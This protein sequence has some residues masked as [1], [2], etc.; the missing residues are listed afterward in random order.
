MVVID[1]SRYQAPTPVQ[2]KVAFR[3]QPP[4]SEKVKKYSHDHLNDTVSI[5]STEEKRF[6][7]RTH[8]ETTR[9]RREPED[10]YGLAHWPCVFTPKR[11]ANV[12]SQL[13]LKT[14]AIG[15]FI[16]LHVLVASESTTE[17]ATSGEGSATTQTSSGKR[18]RKWRYGRYKGPSS[19]CMT[20]LSKYLV[21]NIQTNLFYPLSQRALEKMSLGYRATQS[22]R[23]YSC[24]YSRTKR[25]HNS[26]D[27]LFYLHQ[28]KKE[29]RGKHI[30]ML[31][32]SFST[33]LM[34][35]RRI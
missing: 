13:T 14:Y 33:K 35:W 4:R 18:A 28:F 22:A 21:I 11:N 9:K 16:G 1:P 29:A 15:S 8:Q 23:R 25:M 17:T 32:L 26:N 27:A 2:R 19:M 6:L 7:E 20:K 12:Q 31:T 10:R 3:Y 30:L 5:P 34:L 24:S